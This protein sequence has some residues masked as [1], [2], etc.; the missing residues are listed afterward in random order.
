MR[1]GFACAVALIILSGAA[2]A[3]ESGANQF[4]VFLNNIPHKMSGTVRPCTPLMARFVHPDPHVSRV[5]MRYPYDHNLFIFFP[6]NRE[7]NITL[8]QDYMEKGEWS[9]SDF[10]AEDES[11]VQYGQMTLTFQ[12]LDPQNKGMCES[13]PDS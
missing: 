10:I 7:I 8:H 5:R 13:Y 6:M 4:T 2:H 9:L 3:E 12:P 11:G 1:F